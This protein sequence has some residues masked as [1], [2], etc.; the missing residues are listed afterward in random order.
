MVYA[1]KVNPASGITGVFAYIIA[2]CRLLA[3]FYFAYN[4]LHALPTHPRLRTQ[5]LHPVS[6]HRLSIRYFPQALSSRNE[7]PLGSKPGNDIQAH[8]G[9]RLLGE[10]KTQQNRR[11]RRE[12]A[13]MDGLQRSV[14]GR[15][16]KRC[17]SL[18]SLCLVPCILWA[19]LL[20]LFV[21]IVQCLTIKSGLAYNQ[22]VNNLTSQAATMS[23]HGV[24]ND[25]LSNLD[26]FALLIFIPLCDQIV[27]VS[28][29]A[30][31]AIHSQHFR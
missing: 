13:A 26:P 23:T 21:L 11:P 29:F 10:R 16:E 27:G 18:R 4:H 17:K 14:G 6:T 2:V 31:A 8:D 7:R 12:A 15:S 30:R 3:V 1:E 19:S 24:P 28:R 20:P 9:W 5:P 22:L 25:V